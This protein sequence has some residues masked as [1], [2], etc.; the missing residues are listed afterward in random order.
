M[1]YTLQQHLDDIAF[2]RRPCDMCG[3]DLAVVDEKTMRCQCGDSVLRV[4]GMTISREC[5]MRV[6]LGPPL[7]TYGFVV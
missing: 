7:L 1:S 5:S 6:D 3:G 2:L 4:D